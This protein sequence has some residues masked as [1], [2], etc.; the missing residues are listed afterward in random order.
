MFRNYLKIALRNIS[1]HKMFTLINILSLSIGIALCIITITTV[2]Y[3]LSFDNYHD[4]P[5]QIY[6][7]VT[8]FNYPEGT[9]HSS[10]IPS[11]IGQALRN[12][13]PSIKKIGL[14]RGFD[15]IQIAIQNNGKRIERFIENG[16]VAFAEKSFFDIFDYKVINGDPRNTLLAPNMAVITEKYAKKYFNNQNPLGKTIL[17]DNR[18]GVKIVGILKDIPENTEFR[19]QI[20][21]SYGTLNTYSPNYLDNWSMVSGTT[22]CFI[23]FPEE[24]DIAHF[25]IDLE[26]FVKK[27]QGDV[28]K[29]YSHILQPLNEMHSN[30]DYGGY[31]D[32]TLLWALLLI[33]VFLLLIACCNFVN[34]VTAQSFKRAKEIGVRKVFGGT[35]KMI[36]WQF[37][38]ETTFTVVF[39]VILSVIFVKL[40]LPSFNQII[41]SQLTFNISQDLSV[42]LLLLTLTIIIIFLAGFYP[43]VILSGF[44]PILALKGKV[45]E[46]GITVRKGLVVFQFVISQVLILGTL[47][48]ALQINYIRNTDLGFKKDNIILLPIP[49]QNSVTLNSLKERL[50]AITQIEDVSFSIAPPASLNNSFNSSFRFFGQNT[51]EGNQ[52]YARNADSD[53]LKT[54]DL[55]LIAGRNLS[56]SDTVRE[57]LVNEAFLKVN[58]IDKPEE[59]LG[60]LLEVN[61]QRYP[62]VGVVRNFHFQSAHNS[63]KPCFIASNYQMYRFVGIKINMSD[64]KNLIPAIKK[65]W[66]SSFPE[67]VF[68]YD[69]LDHQ[70]LNFYIVE[71]T[72]LK[73]INFFTA[74]AILLSCLGVY[75]LISYIVNQKKKEIAIRK[76]SGASTFRILWLFFNDFFRLITTAFIIAAPIAWF[77]MNAW[78]QDFSLRIELGIGLFIITL[79]VMVIVTMII[80]SYQSL[81]A[82]TTQPIE[83]LKTE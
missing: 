31:A 20:F 58:N 62:I 67:D 65:I 81:K 73:L 83:S 70:I 56:K 72:L 63:I 16:T 6:R 79:F 46:K 30:P 27:Y 45:V 37:M 82:A 13:F 41:Q 18:Q 23:K 10:G 14:I 42:L 64:S 4:N 76:I 54:Y 7:V 51:I 35:Q 47:V 78:L 12:D 2:K 11:P 43:A 61:S 57:Y 71:D 24:Q 1:K 49:E 68:E 40:L 59:V 19:Y 25:K 34:L 75:G 29:E 15:N 26:R 21:I 32:K 52:I 17:L 28:R 55:Q 44:S 39:S 60:K 74:I 38:L 33:G 50:R 69:Y 22:H 36:F 8:D 48:I 3:H 53:Y 5:S 77:G 66:T 9:K 80:I